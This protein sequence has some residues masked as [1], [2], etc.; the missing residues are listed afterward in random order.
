MAIINDSDLLTDSIKVIKEH[1]AENSGGYELSTSEITQYLNHDFYSK[2]VDAMYEVQERK[3][4][5]LADSI[6]KEQ[7]KKYEDFEECLALTHKVKR[8]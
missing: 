5:E 2:M 6:I 8:I 4:R 3:L 1:I 7:D